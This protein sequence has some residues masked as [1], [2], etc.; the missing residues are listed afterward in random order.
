[1]DLDT[2]KIITP[3]SGTIFTDIADAVDSA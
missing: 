3:L 1:M 2:Q